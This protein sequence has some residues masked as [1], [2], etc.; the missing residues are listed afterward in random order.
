[1]KATTIDHGANKVTVSSGDTYN[2]GAGG[3]GT[4]WN[5]VTL[6][7]LDAIPAPYVAD[8]GDGGHFVSRR[9]AVAATG[10]TS[11]MTSAQFPG[12]SDAT[13]VEDIVFLK[14]QYGLAATSASTVVSSWVDGTAVL[15]NNDAA[16]IIAVRVGVIARSPLLE[17]DAATTSAANATISILPAIAGAGTL[18]A[19]SSGECATQATTMEVKCTVADTHY[20]YRAYST[21]VPLKN[22]IWTR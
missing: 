14:A 6:T 2:P 13:V 9:Y 11:V 8:L 3:G 10:I 17:K 22:V 18:S 5:T 20:R 1:M 15:D 16:R 19:P 4:G 12:F 21:I 7:D